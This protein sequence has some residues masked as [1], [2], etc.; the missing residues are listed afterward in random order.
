[1]SLDVELRPL[2]IIDVEQAQRWYDDQKPGLGGEF[3]DALDEFKRRISINPLL[4]EE[5]RINTR[6]GLLRRFPYLVVYRVFPE[7][8]EVIAV[9]HA[10]RNPSIWQSRL[11]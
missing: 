5:V 2:A 8:L 1:M 6:M 10:H 4:Y 3:L 9:V 7:V 11:S